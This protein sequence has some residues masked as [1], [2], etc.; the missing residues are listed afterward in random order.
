MT[1][2]VALPTVISNFSREENSK[3]FEMQLCEVAASCV[4]D[5][6]TTVKLTVNEVLLSE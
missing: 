6:I 1:C 4:T 3:F 5:K 2:N